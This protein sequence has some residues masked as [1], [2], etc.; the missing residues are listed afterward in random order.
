MSTLRAT[1]TSSGGRVTVALAGTLDISTM[2]HALHEL[3]EVSGDA[4]ALVI[5]LRGLDF[6]DSSGLSVIART[7][8]QAG[9]AGVTVTVIP[10][11]TLRRLMEITG[12]AS[13]L[14]LEDSDG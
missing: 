6:V 11:Q 3:G 1:A 9:E 13:H 5:D 10:N 12:I 14:H 8:L 7:A 2:D 4:S